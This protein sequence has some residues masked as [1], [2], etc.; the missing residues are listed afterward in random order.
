MPLGK[1]IRGSNM[2][3][4]LIDDD[5]DVDNPPSTPVSLLHTKYSV[6][7]KSGRYACR[8]DSRNTVVHLPAGPTAS[9]SL[10]T[11]NSHSEDATMPGLSTDTDVQED[12]E[13]QEDGFEEGQVE[14][15][16]LRELEEMSLLDKP[17]RKRTAGVS[18]FTAM[19]S[20]R[21]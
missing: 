5:D 10:S 9:T 13:G 8:M 3:E 15:E 14:P 2:R 20:P 7:K 16:Y 4:W 6:T 1:R 12:Q 21:N 18:T 11:A 19:H 17:P